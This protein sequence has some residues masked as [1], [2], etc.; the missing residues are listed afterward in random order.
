MGLERRA[1]PGGEM[2][3]TLVGL[4]AAESCRGVLLRGMT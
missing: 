2:P 1:E 3:P 4:R